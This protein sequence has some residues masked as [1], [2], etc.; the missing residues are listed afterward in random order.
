MTTPKT[1]LFLW[2]F[3]SL[4]KNIIERSK[5]LLSWKWKRA[6]FLLGVQNCFSFKKPSN[7]CG[8]MR[9]KLLKWDE[10]NVCPTILFGACK[11]GS[12]QHRPC[13]PPVTV[14]PREA[15]T[16]W[17]EILWFC[18]PNNPFLRYLG[19]YQWRICTYLQ[20][21]VAGKAFVAHPI[22]TW[23]PTPQLSPGSLT[24]ISS[25][26][27]PATASLGFHTAIHGDAPALPSLLH[28][29]WEPS[30]FPNLSQSRIFQ[31]VLF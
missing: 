26:L 13:S 7:D 12:S 24:G 25:C 31:T 8:L 5:N 27:S 18:D 17:V 3:L 19:N 9:Q 30:H 6:P 14:G 28:A 10:E 11:V 16:S 20:P 22:C 23:F 1:L 2:L 15:E 4:Q 21:D 29:V